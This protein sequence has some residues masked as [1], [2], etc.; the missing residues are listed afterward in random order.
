MRVLWRAFIAALWEHFAWK[1]EEYLGFS[2]RS[3]AVVWL[4]HFWVMGQGALDI[5][6]GG[7]S[8]KQPVQCAT[9]R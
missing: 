7:A 9:R 6:G 3:V 1:F 4:P 5:R 8:P 2:S